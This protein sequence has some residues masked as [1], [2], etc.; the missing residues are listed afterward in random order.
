MNWQTVL[1]AAGAVVLLANAGKAII[2][3]ARPAW[4]FGRRVADSAQDAE[5]LEE[6]RG[7]A[8]L[9]IEALEDK[10]RSDYA[11][12]QDVRRAIKVLCGAMLALLDHEITGNHVERLEAAKEQIRDY[13]IER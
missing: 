4:K 1:A 12:I 10:S 9:R 11:A 8:E 2:G 3:V 7:K 5:K 13:L 6:W